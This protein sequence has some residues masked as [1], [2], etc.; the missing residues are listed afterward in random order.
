M[1]SPGISIQWEMVFRIVNLFT[2]D[3]AALVAQK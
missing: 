1:V 3:N 2:E